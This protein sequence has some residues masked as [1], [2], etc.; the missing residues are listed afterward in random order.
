MGQAWIFRNWPSRIAYFVSGKDGVV[1][2]LSL[3]NVVLY[4]IAL[5]IILRRAH[6]FDEQGD[7]YTSNICI[8]SLTVLLPVSTSVEA[9][10]LYVVLIEK[11]I[12]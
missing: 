5:P 12:I 6:F 11:I 7:G 3:L 1:I 8:V 2:F 10:I 9:L 4:I